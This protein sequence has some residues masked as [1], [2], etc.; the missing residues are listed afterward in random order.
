LEEGRGF[1]LKFPADEEEDVS[2]IFIRIAGD[3]SSNAP[4]RPAT[5]ATLL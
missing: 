1:L 4:R 3:I 5:I 2:S